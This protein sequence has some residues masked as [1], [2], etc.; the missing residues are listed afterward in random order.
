LPFE[1]DLPDKGTYRLFLQVQR[2]GALHLLP[3][4]V[5]AS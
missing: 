5:T 2:A 3:L 1:V 4:T